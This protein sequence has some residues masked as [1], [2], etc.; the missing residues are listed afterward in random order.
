MTRR[1]DGLRGAIAMTEGELSEVLSRLRGKVTGLVSDL[2]AFAESIADGSLDI[3]VT[4]AGVV[5][6]RGYE[7][8]VLCAEAFQLRE[9][10]TTLRGLQAE[11]RRGAEGGVED[12]R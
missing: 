4:N 2:T 7:I 8:D 9:K 1:E 6:G 12:D 11:E 10:L 5:Q 3:R